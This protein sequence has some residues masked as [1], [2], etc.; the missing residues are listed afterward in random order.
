MPKLKFECH[1]CNTVSPNFSE[2]V[3]HF[4]ENHRNEEHVVYELLA[5]TNGTPAVIRKDKLE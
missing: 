5:D 1:Y 4:E 2:A 3:K